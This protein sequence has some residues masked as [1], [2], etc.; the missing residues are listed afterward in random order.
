MERRLEVNKYAKW[1]RVALW[2]GIVANLLL[3]L[4]GIFFPNTML[5]LLNQRPS[6]DILWTAFAS[7][8][9]VVLA[10]MYSPA[11]GDLFRYR[12]TARNAVLSRAICAIFFLLL[13]S[14]YLAFGLMDLIFFLIQAPLL[15]LALKEHDK[16]SSVS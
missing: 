12:L 9:V 10:L 2:V 13:W 5:R 16:H 3:G 4:P 7:T 14:G 15:Y 1:F 6:T 8:L 11:G